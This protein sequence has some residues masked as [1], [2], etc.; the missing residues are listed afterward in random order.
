MD[1]IAIDPSLVCTALV[2]NDKKFVYTGN[3]ISHTEKGKLKRW[4]ELFDDIVTVR[5]FNL[6]ADSS[7]S[8]AERE[9]AKLNKYVKI[10]SAI[11]DDI[12]VECKDLHTAKVAIE[13]YSFSSTA[14]P[15][16]DL[17]T[18]GTIL[19]YSLLEASVGQIIIVA[20]QEL[21][22]RAASLSYPPTKK[23]K[24]VKYVNADG[25]AAGSFKKQDM[26]RCL[27]DMPNTGSDVWI[28]R[29]REYKDDAL[30]LKATPKPLEDVNDA[31]LLY[32]WLIRN[33]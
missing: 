30:S 21:K 5:S 6:S 14:G 17:V 20:P 28:E 33:P 9:F 7:L 1:C 18:F 2:V 3:H 26:L 11:M 19:R 32:E 4:F 25:K 24:L 15:L 16:I 10:V 13:G 22:S 8:Y 29:L 12:T 31:K 27:I 23:G